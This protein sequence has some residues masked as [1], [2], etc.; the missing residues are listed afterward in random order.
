[1][2]S[3]KVR[4][5]N[6]IMG[7][8][9]I[10]GD[11]LISHR[12]LI[13]GAMSNGPCLIRGFLN[14]DETRV[15]VEALRQLGVVI[16]EKDATSLIVYGNKGD[17]RPSGADIQ[18][19]DSLTSLVLM[20]ALATTCPFRTR[21]SASPALSE[22]PLRRV[23]EP[24]RQM[25][26][27]IEGSGPN[28]DCPPLDIEGRPLKGIHFQMPAMVADAKSALL[29][30][31]LRAQGRTRIT[32]PY[33]THNHTELMMRYQLASV[34]TEQDDRTVSLCG[35]QQ[36][37]NRDF[38]IPGDMSSA[39]CWL[40]AAS[41][42]PGAQ[43]LVEDVGLNDTRSGFLSVLIRMGANVRESIR[44]DNGFEKRGRIEVRGG[45]LRGT[46]VMGREVPT[47]IQDLPLIAV[48]GALA[49]GTT[50]IRD[51]ADMRVRQ[52]DRITATVENLRR[53]GV[54]VKERDDGMEIVGGKTLNGAKLSTYGDARIGMAF[55]V[56]G[57]F[58]EGE[59]VIE[60]AECI[61]QAYPNFEKNLHFIMLQRRS[62][63]QQV[64]PVVSSLNGLAP[65][66]IERILEE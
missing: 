66:E 60:D 21:I 53:M 51:A 48:A 10:P 34:W 27:F 46:T 31:G 64:I 17:F 65:D 59:T 2:S 39:A 9:R 63:N 61:E 6:E 18:C 19:G 43:L 28:G 57:L 3:L 40:V 56:A 42:R 22:R 62:R 12:A 30:A 47:V 20:T 54:T 50:L 4:A 5:A 33:P 25:G 38:T 49:Q 1:M 23:L 11:R 58:A 8:L 29:I 37:E 15:T 55:A 32:E 45:S 14:T 24:L 36:L 41:A 16:E 52:S 44:H 26:A 35:P 7:E 13:L